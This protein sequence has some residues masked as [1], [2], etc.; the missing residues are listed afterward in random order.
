MK[1]ERWLYFVLFLYECLEILYSGRMESKEVMKSKATAKMDLPSV[2]MQKHVICC[3]GR[4]SVSSGSQSFVA[5]IPLS[6]RN[7][8]NKRKTA[9]YCYWI[10]SGRNVW[11]LW[12]ASANEGSARRP[13][14]VIDSCARR[15]LALLRRNL[16]KFL[17]ELLETH[18][19]GRIIRHTTFSSLVRCKRHWSVTV[20]T[21]TAKSWTMFKTGS[22]FSQITSIS[23]I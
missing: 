20:F 15:T 13:Y 7:V 22:D 21:R 10:F 16:V 19:I 2:V 23:N 18:R 1:T 9:T 8:S 4:L 5:V 6:L 12:S 14:T 11:I 3:G 17:W